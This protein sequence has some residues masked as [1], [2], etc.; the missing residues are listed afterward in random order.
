MPRKSRGPISWIIAVLA[1][2]APII[3]SVYL[4]WYESYSA[5]ESLSLTYAQNVLQRIERTEG[6]LQQAL[7]KIEHSGNVPCS[8]G[9]MQFMNQVGLGSSYL[10][11][12]GRVSGDT[13]LCTSQGVTNAMPLGKPNIVTAEGVSVYFNRKLSST[14]P[15]IV[16]ASRGFAAIVDPNLVADVSTQGTDIELAV[17]VPS[18]PDSDPMIARGQN[19]PAGWSQPIAQGTQTTAMDRGYLVSTVRSANRDLAVLSATPQRY[20]YQRV[21]H[22][23]LYVCPMGVLCGVVLCIAVFLFSRM[24]TS[25][26]IMLRRAIRDK[27]F[28][29]LYQPVIDLKTRRIIG[30]EALVRWKNS[31]ADF[32]PDYFIPQAEECG[33]IHLITNQVI[34]I[35]TRDLPKFLQ[36][37]PDFRVAI[38]MSADDLSNQR[39]IEA[40]DKMLSTTRARPE[41]I[42]IEATERAFLQGPKTAELLDTVRAKGFTIAID[43]FG[44]GYSSL[45][46]LQSLS[47]DTL[48]I[49]KAFVDT[50]GTDGATSQVVLHIMEMAHSLHLEMVAEG[51]ETEPQAI[52]LTKHGVRYAQGWL[53]GRPMDLNQLCQMIRTQAR[54]QAGQ[55]RAALA[56]VLR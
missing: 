5:E 30:A 24:L 33:L 23:A 16:F 32:R 43:D 8:A 31:Y 26:P 17:L 55:R 52:Y 2:F 34:R 47:L 28:Y 42:E 7:D 50:I 11:E 40:L 37:D 41:N 9:D 38:N 13:L 45:S 27:N 1:L 36:I 19:F 49:D 35:V 53:F 25:F 56:P 15:L 21:G 3:A 14:H 18:S 12:I 20:V 22:F 4:A 54:M 39:T 29:V 10:K 44:T 46:C 6:Q 51:V 48:K